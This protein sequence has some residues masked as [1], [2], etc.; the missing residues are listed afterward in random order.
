[1]SN[2]EN[3]RK[4]QYFQVHSRLLPGW[5]KDSES[6]EHYVVHISIYKQLISM[7]WDNKKTLS[8]QKQD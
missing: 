4:K 3:T 1:M 2:T 7:V 5:V 6:V 8:Y